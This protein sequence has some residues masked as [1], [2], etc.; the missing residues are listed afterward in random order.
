M[1]FVAP[2]FSAIGGA[3]GFSGTAA[4]V[5]GVAATGA[6][7][8]SAV[9]KDVRR[10]ALPVLGGMATGGLLAGGAAGA[11]GG[12]IGGLSK[13]SIAG[14]LLGA[15]EGMKMNEAA[16]VQKQQQEY[17]NQQ[18]SLI[19]KQEAEVSRQS[20][21]NAR[22]AR[23]AQLAQQGALDLENERMGRLQQRMLRG[24]RRGLFDDSYYGNLN[25][26]LG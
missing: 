16:K 1:G 8:A 24:R 22:R 9:N 13:G 25:S 23:V 26:L 19:A 3:L 12:A 7:V 10:V 5:A 6:G 14:G 4:T 17:Y 18:R 15:S 2:V 11:G 20:A 21:E